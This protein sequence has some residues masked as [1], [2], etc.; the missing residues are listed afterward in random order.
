VYGDDEKTLLW[1]NLENIAISSNSREHSEE[2]RSFLAKR[3]G[4]SYWIGALM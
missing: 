1:V 4:A 3:S 2:E